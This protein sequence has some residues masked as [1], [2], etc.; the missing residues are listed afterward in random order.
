MPS[1]P[2]RLAA[3]IILGTLLS[4]FGVLF[5]APGSALGAE[6]QPYVSIPDTISAKAQAYLRTLTDPALIPPW[7]ERNDA[8]GW[9][10]LVRTYEDK[11]APLT[12]AAIKTF[13]P[14][15]IERTLGGVPVIEIRPKG[16]KDD[17]KVVVYTHG[18]GYVLFSAR[19]TLDSSVRV[20][21]I[22]GRRIIAIDYTLAP[23][24]RW[25]AM[26]DQVVSAFRAL[27]SEG[28]TMKDIALYG[29]SAGGGLAAGSVLKMRDKGL[30]M[31]A[32]LVL[33]SPWADIT[34]SGDT[35]ETL[36]HAEPRFLYKS[37][38]RKA[39]EAYADEN[40]WKTPY[41]SPVYGDF[42][43]GYPPTLIQGGTKELF[44][45]HFVRLY[46]AI[47]TAG[48]VVKLDLYDGMPHV[49]QWFIPEAP[50]GTAAFAKMK[51]FI[52]QHLKR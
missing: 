31:P 15:L 6:D 8:E 48:G 13:Q 49:F 28:F 26:T 14:T 30:G 51:T 24:A 32:V 4:S 7:P 27:L 47:D 21:D 3:T 36:K 37:Q 50:E 39:A 29:D 23:S 35:A 1:R 34:N 40:A 5:Q 33:W 9:R 10:K 22:L 44:V 2:S 19:S 12:E 42:S 41:V 46:Q 16:W 38:L 45:S 52:D 43:K 11:C 17:G 25:D 18:G 20:A